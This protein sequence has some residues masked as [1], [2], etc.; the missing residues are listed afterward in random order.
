M[1]LKSKLALL[2]FIF[3]A[4]ACNNSTTLQKN[5]E[6]PTSGNLSIYCDEGLY[7]HVTNQAATFTGIYP[8]ANFKVVISGED[9][10]VAALYN[11]SCE[12]IVICRDLNAKEKAA[13]LSKKYTTSHSIV[14]QTAVAC[15]VNSNS[16]IKC[17]SDKEIKEFLKGEKLLRDS[18]D[19][20]L[21]LELVVDRIN[22]GVLHYLLD[23]VVQ[24]KTL[25]IG[26][27]IAGS[28]TE[29]INYVASHPNSIT[30]IDFA[31][32]SDQDSQ[33]WKEVSNKI[34][35]V[36]LAQAGDSVY[37]PPHQSSIKLGNYPFIRSIYVHRKSGEFTLSKGFESFV[38]GPKGQLIF[39]KQGLL[40]KKQQ[41]RSIHIN[42]G[43][44]QEN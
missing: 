5:E 19:N 13:F 4:V 21:K 14:A 44:N 28:S 23:S 11:D 15:I 1:K 40:P 10:A 27:K 42:T 17:A 26:A 20:D 36:P 29:A 6:S 8:K 33:L 24:S 25:A 3:F 31:W 7:S 35:L 2:I 9:E 32:I 39:L 43:Q 37:E 34:K 38:M 18:L 12:S 30:F 41:E 22:S 16:T